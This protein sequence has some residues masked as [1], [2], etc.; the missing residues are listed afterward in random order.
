MQVS[1]EWAEPSSQNR[2]PVGQAPHK[3]GQSLYVVSRLFSEGFIAPGELDPLN[4]RQA[5]LPKPDFIAQSK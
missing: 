2:V 4:R 1:E 3:W 5:I